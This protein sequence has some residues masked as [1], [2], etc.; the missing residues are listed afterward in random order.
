MIAIKYSSGK[1]NCEAW[2][3]GGSW[4]FHTTVYCRPFGTRTLEAQLE[5]S[6]TPTRTKVMPRMPRNEKVR[7][8]ALG[9]FAEKNIA[10]L[11][12]WDLP[13]KSTIKLNRAPRSGGVPGYW[14]R[15]VTITS[16]VAP[17]AG[18]ITTKT[19]RHGENAVNW[20]FTIKQL[21]EDAITVEINA[22][23]AGQSLARSEG[24]KKLPPPVWFSPAFTGGRLETLA[25]INRSTSVFFNMLLSSS[26]RVS[27]VK[28]I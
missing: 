20:A 14:I 5:E 9:A 11:S 7:L 3:P 16:F 2:F 21:S 28:T 17:G 15:N 13:E 26:H 24:Q 18:P 22:G 12:V 23:P 4:I 10:P 27:A 1:T 19:L 6:H 8:T 25:S